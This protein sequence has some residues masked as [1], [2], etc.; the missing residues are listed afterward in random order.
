MPV[1]I[2]PPA[3]PQPETESQAQPEWPRWITKSPWPRGRTRNAAP[4]NDEELVID[5]RTFL[6]WHVYLGY[7]DLG[8]VL[9]M[10]RDTEQV[11]KTGML[12]VWP[13]DAP[14]GTEYFTAFLRP[15]IQTVEIRSQALGNEVLYDLRCV[16][17]A[18]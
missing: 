9:P 3:P 1:T 17:R 5:N 10:S 12:N 14:V 6:A 7:R 15:S 2:E 11:I 4:V 13:V 18:G 16:E 8:V